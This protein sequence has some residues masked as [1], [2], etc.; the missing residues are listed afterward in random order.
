MG[1][2]LQLYEALASLPEAR[3][4]WS[5]VAVPASTCAAPVLVRGAGELGCIDAAHRLLRGFIAVEL[6]NPRQQL[7][8]LWEENRS[9]NPETWLLISI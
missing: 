4:A 8:G 9:S 6:P 7:G 2:E 5:P 3:L 1:P